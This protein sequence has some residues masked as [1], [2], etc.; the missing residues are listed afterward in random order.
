MAIGGAVDEDR[1][2]D[3]RTSLII[4]I[5]CGEAGHVLKLIK[6]RTERHGWDTQYGVRLS[7]LNAETSEEGHWASIGGPILQIVSANEGDNCGTWFAVRQ[8]TTTTIFRPIYRKIPKPFKAPLPCS[9]GYPPS[10]LDANPVVVLDPRRDGSG[11]HADVSFNPWYVRQFAVVDEAGKWSSWNIEGRQTKRSNM[12]IAAVKTGHIYD[13]FDLEPHS[14]AKLP[15]DVGE[16]HRIL[17]AGSVSTIVVMNRRHL[18]VF[19]TKLEPRRLS[20]VEFT[21]ATMNEWILDVKR[22][23]MNPGHLLILTT[24]R[25]FWL[26]IVPAGEDGVDRDAGVNILLSQRHFRDSTD[27][28]MKLT[29]SKDDDG[30]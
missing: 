3:S 18:A 26:N 29:L 12:A 17:W 19:D 6:P 10:R 7:L 4:A 27:E 30:M 28:A 9:A 23:T 2:F 13:D 24:G 11:N 1:G 25:L 21:K 5:P 8:A 14:T 22:S 16:W 20:S 15:G